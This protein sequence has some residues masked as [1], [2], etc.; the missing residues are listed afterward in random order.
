MEFRQRRAYGLV[1]VGTFTY[2]FLLFVWFSLPA[3]LTTIIE[4]LGLSGFEAGIVVG[5]VP[6]T[7]IPIALFSGVAVDRIGPGRSLA[8]GVVV[9]GTAQIGRSYASGFPSLLALTVLLGVGATAITFGLPKLVSVL[10]P[11]DKTGLPSSI[12]LLGASLGSAL[13]FAVGRPILGPAL[14]GWRPLFF[15]SGVL[16]VVYGL[17]WYTV[18]RWA[19]IDAA[20][21]ET[22]ASFS[23]DSVRDDLTLVLSHRELR[24]VVVVGTMFLLLQHGLQGWLPTILEGRG[25]TPGRAGQITSLFVVALATGVLFIPPLADRLSARRSTLIACGSVIAV[26]VVGLITGGFGLVLFAGIIA[27]GI[28][29]GGV[30][31][32]IRALPPELEGIGTER[33]GAAVGFIFA[34]GE[35]GGFLGPVLIGTFRDV[36]QSFL[37]GLV[38]LAG[39]GVVILVAGEKL[40]RAA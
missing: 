22:D 6:L 33:T 12:Y 40:R 16:A 20:V 27:T 4:E 10:F 25:F 31:P 15:W 17:L 30:S 18:S 35:I 23:F 1:I 5:A 36:T 21:S 7:Y 9:F 26:G 3:Y 38:I 13:V 8:A 19:N 37:P 11:P 32:L 39:G 34:V 14:G 29:A 28:G 24:L 2:T